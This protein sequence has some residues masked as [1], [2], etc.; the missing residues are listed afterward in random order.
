M[1]ML[2]ATYESCVAGLGPWFNV[3]EVRGRPPPMKRQI[4]V[5]TLA[6]AAALVLFSATTSRSE[7][8]THRYS[9][10]D[11]A[12]STNFADSVGGPSWNGTLVNT[13]TL[14]GSQMQLDG[15]GWAAL[16]G[17]ISS[18][19]SQ[20]TIEFWATYFNSNPTW[21]RTFAF[22]DQNAGN[23]NTGVDYCHYAPGS[24]QNLNI[25]SPSASGYAN[26]PGGLNGS[27]NVHVTVV[28]DPANTN[29]YY[30]NATT[31]LPTLHGGVP[32][33][34]TINDTTCLLGKS[35]FDADSPVMGSLNEFRIY[36]GVIRLSQLALNDA[37]G[38]DLIVTNPGP[39]QALHFSSPV[40]PLIVN[41]SSQQILRGDFTNLTG[42]DFIAY[43][44][45]T[46]ASS[47]TTI[48]T[49]N[50]NGVVK[51]VAPGTTK[52]VAVF[53]GLS[54]TNALTVVAVPAT[55]AHRYS[56]TTDA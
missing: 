43:G 48:L 26:N 4:P 24:W 28:V 47:N 50:T 54:V 31:F 12:G 55:L 49:I 2:V 40:N 27:T 19:Y 35:L 8:L 38:P 36:Q 5:L 16:P 9:F 23:E 14:D 46:F 20:V 32:P 25:Q 10:N 42:V 51:A 17:G 7:T 44:G 37:A 53:G 56:F 52:V 34:N 39:V 1:Q 3:D 18:S 6:S 29:M 21:T 22:G 11:P 33:L 45:A 13:A 15:G 30:Y 41:Q